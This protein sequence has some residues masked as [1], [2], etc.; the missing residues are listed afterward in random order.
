MSS[1]GGIFCINLVKRYDRRKQVLKDLSDFS[2]ELVP[3][4]DSSETADSRKEY[5][6]P[7][8]ACI[9]S[10]IK[11]LCLYLERE[12][13]KPALVFEDDAFPKVD[14]IV[15]EVASTMMFAPKKWNLIL[16]G[17]GPL[18]SVKPIN[19]RI[20][21]PVGSDGSH[22]Y[23]ISRL[24]AKRLLPLLDSTREPFDVQLHKLL[25]K[26][27]LATTK[28]LFGQRAGFSDIQFIEKMEY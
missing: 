23:L 16:L 21:S 25:G 7:V 24:G 13:E 8:R 3:A 15:C 10:H 22:A 2:L 17:Y 26:S 6:P 18:V 11:T 14:K 5:S 12:T 27:L 20:G 9:E 1:F 4:V 19:H 28:V